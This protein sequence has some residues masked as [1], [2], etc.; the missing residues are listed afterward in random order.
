[1]YQINQDKEWDT[2]LWQKLMMH[3]RVSFSKESAEHKNKLTQ[4]GALPTFD[5]NYDWA[6]LCIAYCFAT[7]N[8]LPPKLQPA[9]E[10]QSSSSLDFRTLFQKKH[11]LWLAYIS[12]ALFEYKQE[13]CQPDDL[14][15]YITDLW[16][17]GALVLWQ[18]WERCRQFEPDSL[19]KAKQLFLREL[20]DLAKKNSGSRTVSS[21][22]ENG[23]DINELSAQ[24]SENQLKEALKNMDL[25]IKQLKF[26]Q[27]GVRE[28]IYR[29]SLNKYVDLARS[30]DELCSN[31]G[32]DNK[33]L[34]IKR[35][36]DG[37]ANSYEIFVQRPK[38]TWRQFGQPEFQAALK[39]YSGQDLLPICLGFNE[40]GEAFFADL[41]IA[42]HVMIG[43]TTGSGKSVFVRSVLH[44]LFAL[45]D[46]HGKLEVAIADG[47][48]MDFQSF[49]K[50][51]NLYQQ[52]IFVSPE[53]IAPMLNEHLADMET[54]KSLCKQYG[55][56]HVADLPNNIRPPYRVIV[57][58]ELAYLKEHDK[59]G[60]MESALVQLTAQARAT[61]IYLI[62]CTQRPDSTTFKGQ[63][64]T[65]TPS[66]IALKVSKSTESK[67][68]LD[69]TGAEKLSGR[70][71]HLVKWTEVSETVFLHGFNV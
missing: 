7:G 22:P 30:H 15:K 59:N 33:Q 53:E 11:Q 54:R 17:T 12:D 60:E 57:V 63:L 21:Q 56:S 69:E 32:M 14:Y 51:P 70:G 37:E 44:S 36:T 50:Y 49:E 28:D 71:D 47:K 8:H 55:V 61:G 31:L 27:Q 9:S 41:A 19:L 18:K 25:S 13:P 68:I 67:I 20:A 52:R 10:L 64:R 42:P 62:L 26:S 66:R 3:K 43:G 39:T 5:N 1:M 40:L 6:M 16:H 65:N 4:T 45:N 23:D 24:I 35:C 38:N 34:R 58:D 46:A 2:D 29:L 48:S